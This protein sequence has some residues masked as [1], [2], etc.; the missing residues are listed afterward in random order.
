MGRSLQPVRGQMIGDLADPSHVSFPALNA[1]FQVDRAGPRLWYTETRDIPG[2]D[3]LYEIGADIAYVIGSGTKGQSFLSEQDGFLTQAPVSWFA[4]KRIW[5]LSPGFPPDLHVGRPIEAGCLFC[6]ANLVTPVP[7]TQ[8]RYEQPVFPSGHAIGCERCHGPG[9][10]HVRQREAGALGDG[11]DHSIVNPRHLDPTLR[12]AVCQQCHLAGESRILRAG[13]ELSDFRPGL[14]LDSVIRVLVQDHKGGDRKAVNHAEQLLMSKCYTASGGAL[15]CATC[16]D[17]HQKLP[18]DRRAE[19]YRAA[20]LKC[21]DCTTPL[22]ART[23]NG[24]TN[25]CATCHMPRFTAGDIVHA[26]STNHRITRT[27]EPSKSSGLPGAIT[28]PLLFFPPRPPD[29]RRIDEGRDYAVGLVELAK[30]GRIPPAEVARDVLPLLERAITEAPSDHRAW[31]AKS[32]AL[33]YAGRNSEAFAAAQT[34][35]SLVPNDEAGLT[36][37]AVMAAEVGRVD[38]SLEYWRRALALNPR[39][40]AHRQELALLLAR[41]GDWPGARSEAEQAIRLDPARAQVRA[42]LA[43]ASVRAGDKAAG[44]ALFRTVELLGPP[45]LSDLRRWYTAER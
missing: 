33:Q 21:H 24:A 4:Q 27:G 20:C 41:S 15:G 28:R 8:N 1:H 30:F 37:A 34:L 13:R 23:A 2:A 29:L 18:A 25:D 40:A 9:A 22:T 5:D 11:V 7:G 35:L 42:I 17:P 44:D 39:N 10:E 26:A 12:E 19:R 43:I 45:N 3:P 32:Y 16:H 6:H 14:P 36:H 31:N 38:L